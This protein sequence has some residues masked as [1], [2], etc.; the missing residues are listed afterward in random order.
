VEHAEQEQPVLTDEERK[1]AVQVGIAKAEA[2]NGYL[3]ADGD[4]S[5][6]FDQGAFHLSILAILDEQCKVRVNRDGEKRENSLSKGPFTKKVFPETDSEADDEI[7]KLVW[8]DLTRR[9]WSALNPNQSSAMQKLVATLDPEDNRPKWVLVKTNVSHHGTSIES[10]FITNNH[11]VLDDTFNK[12]LFHEIEKV[13]L[14]VAR[15]EVMLME[16]GYDA[17][18]VDRLLKKRMKQVRDLASNMT[19][20]LLP[21]GEQDE[22][23]E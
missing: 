13:T 2:A 19:A 3:I 22:D 15:N 8:A 10:V 11:D 21:N 6:E 14:K 7:G 20:P 12:T 16:R 9:V 5:G 17:K 1:V 23:Q 18:R 4:S